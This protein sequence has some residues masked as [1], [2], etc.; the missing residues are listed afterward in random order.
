MFNVPADALFMAAT[1]VVREHYKLKDADAKKMALVFRTGTTMATWGFTVTVVIQAS[2]DNQSI[3]GM[4]VD[5]G[6]NYG[7]GAQGR[8]ATKFFD[9]IEEELKNN[10]VSTQNTQAAG[11]AARETDSSPAEGADLKPSSS[12]RALTNDDILG[13]IGA[14]LPTE[15]IVAK[16]KSSPGVFD[17]SPGTLSQLA[18]AKVPDSVLL[19]MVQGQETRSQKQEVPNGRI[20]GTLTYFFNYNYGNKPDVGAVVWLV[21]G[22]VDIPETAYF[23]GPENIMTVAG[24]VQYEPIMRT[25]ADGDGNFVLPDV[26]PGAYTVIAESA[27]RNGTSA[28]DKPGKVATF[29]VAVKPG[30]ASVC[31]WNFGL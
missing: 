24:P 11:P 8:F 5:N 2:G 30:E 26:R 23:H 9:W 29:Q 25:V 17:T 10:S 14:G 12:E 6:G 27:H 15:V 22:F 31:S 18:A 4:N 1:K 19:A 28:R 7:W 13:M 3:L 21:R 16:I 20:T